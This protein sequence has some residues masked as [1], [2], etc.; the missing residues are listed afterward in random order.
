MNGEIDKD[1]HDSHKATK[2]VTAQ[3]IRGLMMLM[4]IRLQAIMI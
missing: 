3:E 4:L 2:L 1:I